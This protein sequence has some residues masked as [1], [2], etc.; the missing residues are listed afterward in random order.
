MTLTT[1][2]NRLKNIFLIIA[3]N[4]FFSVLFL[5]SCKVSQPPKYF[6]D[7][8][9]DTIISRTTH[10]SELLK[11]K[12]GDLL[13]ITITSISP[14]NTAIFN[15]SGI[16]SSTA[17]NSSQGVSYKVDEEGNI[18]IIKLGKIRAEGI[19]TKGL[20]V[21]LEGLL[22]PYLREPLVT[23]KFANH[24]VTVMGQVVRPQVVPIQG[25]EDLTLLQA[26][27][28]AGDITEIGKKE[29]VLIVRE[30]DTGRIFRRVNLTTPKL[31]TSPYYYLQPDDI[32]YVE[33]RNVKT[34]V[35]PQVQQILTLS[36][37]VISL[38]LIFIRGFK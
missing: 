5:S 10:N 4:L 3:G 27:L 25:D 24:K 12:K 22:P 26:L 1:P 32:V 11:I 6:G 13:A 9:K 19:T 2:K 36:L 21:K 34:L 33:G 30:T 7:I 16:V 35:T 15:S 23:V 37:S 17:N 20:K 38:A 28:I 18:E 14:E 31:F 29:N 8:Q